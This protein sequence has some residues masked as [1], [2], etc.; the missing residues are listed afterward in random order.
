MDY[1]SS[2][3]KKTILFVTCLSSFLTAFMSSSVNI[4][5]KVIGEEYKMDA[6]TLS[7]VATSYLLSTAVF[8][9][10]F[11]KIADIY[12]RKKIFIIGLIVYSLFSFLTIFAPD[13]ITLIT[14]RVLQGMGGAMLFGTTM[15]IITS[16]YSSGERGKA[17]GIYI[18]SVYIGLSL[19]PVLGGILTHNF[20][21]K[22]IFL[23]NFPLGIICIILVFIIMKH[24]WAEAKQDKFD[25]FGSI[26]Y[27]LS[28]LAIM[29]GLSKIPHYEGFM[30]LIIGIIILTGFVIWEMKI[31]HP[32]LNMNLFRNNRT[33]KFSSLAALINYSAT[34]AVTFL[35]SLYLQYIKQMTPQQAG[36]ILVFQPVTMAVFASY[37]GRLSDR[38]E[39]RIISTIGM[40]FT[41]FGIIMLAL[42]SEST[43]VF[44][45]IFCMIFL[46]L[47]FGF[48]SSPNS[49]AIM[50]AVES[51][52]FGIAS[53]ILSTMRLCGQMLSMGIATLVISIFIG[54]VQITHKYHFQL[55]QSIKIVFT[56]CAA[57]C[58]LGIFA[59]LTKGEKR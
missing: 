13:S 17:I 9:V 40:S 51:K 43:P 47:G 6:I 29:Y 16:V 35:M 11:G 41:V 25:I 27:G 28:L 33:F 55:M 44:Y 8:L 23:I 20:G 30:F 42:M 46:G 21:W 19:G 45:I 18:S 48:F 5:I 50:S 59:S 12:G 57:L 58:I 26:I 24:E 31:K 1:Y 39:A 37:A 14:L 7:W 49:N 54:T 4:A 15:A 32:I 2:S 3:E 53:A 10:P 56:I 22:S 38:H 34:F 52:N 36:F